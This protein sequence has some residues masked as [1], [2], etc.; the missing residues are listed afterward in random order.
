MKRWILCK[1]IWGA[2]ASSPKARLF[3]D[4]PPPPRR[5]HAGG[6]AP[7]PGTL[8]APL[9]IVYE[10]DLDGSTTRTSDLSAFCVATVFGHALEVKAHGPC[11]AIQYSLIQRVLSH[12]CYCF[13]LVELSLP[14][15]GV[16][17]QVTSDGI[18][19]TA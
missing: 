1:N 16:F 14:N 7:L 17:F 2:A 4:P 19:R 15:S 11:L 3:S 12:I 10:F 8:P 18:P 5:P 9:L 6:R 13:T